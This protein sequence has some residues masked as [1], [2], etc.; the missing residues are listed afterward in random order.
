MFGP[1]YNVVGFDPRGVGFSGPNIDP[2]NGDRKRA[3]NWNIETNARSPLS[4]EED[5]NAQFEFTSAYGDFSAAKLNK[6]ARYVSTPAVARDMITYIE[7]QAIMSGKNPDEAKLYYAGFSYGTVLGVTVATLY[8]SR[9]GRIVLDGVVDS[10]EYYAGTW[11]T[12]AWDTDAAITSFFRFCYKAGPDRCAFYADSE[13]AIENRYRSLLSHLKDNPISVSDENVVEIP[14][15]ATWNQLRV[16]HFQASYNT[17][18]L[19]PKLSHVLLDLENGNG[20][21]LLQLAGAIPCYDCDKSKI[22][23][24]DTMART[25]ISCAD[26]DARFNLTNVKE[27]KELLQ[28]RTGMSEYAG[29]FAAALNLFCR[30]WTFLPPTSQKFD[31]KCMLDWPLD[32]ETDI[33]SYEHW[34]ERFF[35]Y[36][37]PLQRYRSCDAAQAVSIYAD[38]SRPVTYAY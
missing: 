27:F 12:A 5:L 9:I 8:P 24:T 17:E 35:T 6:T 16:A 14:Q 38:V 30:K 2:F 11:E 37:F 13:R 4:S 7:R 22:K 25:A 20:S 28:A 21:S 15:F 36:S 26:A 34:Q 23:A 19:Y 3:Q 31:R 10:H 29:D 18:A 1:N 32:C 33:L